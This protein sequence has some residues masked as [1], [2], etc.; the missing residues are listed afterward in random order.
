[1][2]L[3][4]IVIYGDERLHSRTEPIEEMTPELRQLIADMGETM[5][6]ASGVGLAGPQVGVLRRVLVL[7]V[8]QVEE[9]RKRS[10]QRLLLRAFVN[11]EI[12]WLSD[13][14]EPF[15]E[16]CLSIPGVEAEVYRPLRVRVRYRDENWVEH[17][18]DIDGLLARVL[19]HEI[20]HLEGVLFV[21]RLAFDKRQALVKQL[22]RLRTERE[23]IVVPAGAE[24]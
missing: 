17:E 4:R 16:G 11:P 10:P 23:S 6:A 24:A 1:M 8:D 20:D 12:L 5:Y 13:E 2:A 18:E 3:L 21:D 9:K 15:S 19:Q 14:D 22:S 7:D